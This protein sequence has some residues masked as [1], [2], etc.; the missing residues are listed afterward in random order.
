MKNPINIMENLHWNNNYGE[1]ELI[2][3]ESDK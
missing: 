2:I 3:S 1:R